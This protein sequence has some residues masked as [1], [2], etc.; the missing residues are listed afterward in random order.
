MSGCEACD[1]STQAGSREEPFLRT[2]LP[3]GGVLI[4]ELPIIP[5]H[6][7]AGCHVCPEWCTQADLR[8]LPLGTVIAS[9]R[10]QAAIYADRTRKHPWPNGWARLEQLACIVADGGPLLHKRFAELLRDPDPAIRWP[11]AVHALQHDIDK[12][13]ALATLRAMV[14]RVLEDGTADGPDGVYY[15][16]RAHFLLIDHEIGNP[17]ELP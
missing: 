3:G 5:E 1:R 2:P 16:N 9:Y 10:R 4:T 15:A 7:R 14:G 6:M 11:V 13:A 12:P 17:I 8:P